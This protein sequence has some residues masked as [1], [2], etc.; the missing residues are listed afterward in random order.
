[1]SAFGPRL[2][3]IRK[4]R[5]MTQAEVAKVGNLQPSAVAHFE[6]GRRKPGSANL[7]RLSD[8][9]GVTTDRLLGLPSR[10]GKPF[11]GE[12]KLTKSQRR[13][14]QDLIDFLIKRER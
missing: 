9:L 10:G 14:I 12:E 4:Q 7:V 13:Q 11:V 6:A 3:G 5:H 1:M 8:A 2:A